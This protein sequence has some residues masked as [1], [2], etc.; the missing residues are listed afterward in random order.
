MAIA[1]KAR[2]GA[3][4]SRSQMLVQILRRSA[5]LC[6]IGLWLSSD[7]WGVWR[8]PGVL[9]YFGFSYCWCALVVVLCGSWDG[10]PG[11]RAQ[12]S[13][14]PTTMPTSPRSSR[15]EDGTMF[16]LFE[17]IPGLRGS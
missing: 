5:T 9:Q 16:R 10:E 11:H 17:V 12:A 3:K 14:E 8:I 2:R 13:L 1:L 6:A 15:V 7:V 4:H